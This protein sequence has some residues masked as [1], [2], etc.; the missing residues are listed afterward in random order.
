MWNWLFTIALLIVA[1]VAVVSLSSLVAAQP[2][3][4]TSRRCGGPRGASSAYVGDI[5][6][7]RVDVDRSAVGIVVGVIAGTGRR[8]VTTY[9]C[10]G[11][12]DPR[13]VA[14]DT[15][16]EI[17]SITKV[18]TSL[19]LADMVQRGE[20]ALDDPAAKYLPPDVQVPQ[21][22]GR[23]ITLQ[24]LAMHTSGLPRLPLDFR[25]TH[26]HNPYADYTTARVFASLSKATLR[27][28]IGTQYEY[29]NVG[30]GLL[31]LALARRAGL[32]Y[33]ALLRAR[34]LAPLRMTSTAI[35][36]SAEMKSRLATGHTAALRP[37][38]PWEF[39]AGGG[40]LAAAG[41]LRSTADDMLT[42]LHAFVGLGNTPPLQ[43]A[44]TA[45]LA[46]RRPTGQAGLGVALGWHIRTSGDKEIVWHNGGTGGYRS[47][48]GYDPRARMGI[49]VLSNAMTPEGVDTIGLHLL[50]PGVRP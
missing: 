37:T 41:G 35:T 26:A 44:L 21:R 42:F 9:G 31:G 28:D 15:V 2:S 23:T 48:I 39:P 20:V 3:P 38:S 22:D 30:A 18:F 50:D 46:T 17:G 27:R 1:S 12:D 45:M 7:R 49:V 43:P 10:H 36:L 24:D 40:G 47:W 4:A 8:G 11:I 25:A 16:F 13:P 32:E 5:L 14:Q 33:E 34:I 6:V 29:S 19:L